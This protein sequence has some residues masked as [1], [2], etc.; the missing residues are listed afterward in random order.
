MRSIYGVGE[1]VLDI[2]FKNGQPVAAKAGGSVL[3]AFVTL[4]RLGIDVQFIS[5]YGT[6]PVGDLIDSFLKENNVSTQYVTR[7]TNGKSTLALA[8]LDEHN[9]ASYSFY[10][11]YPETRLSTLPKELRKDDIL[12]FGSLYAINKE[13]RKPLVTILNRAKTAGSLIFYDPNFRAAHLNELKELKPVIIENLTFADIVRGSDEDF[14]NIFDAGNS[15]EAYEA[16]RQYCPNLV[17]TANREGIFIHTPG[18]RYYLPVNSIEPVSTIGAGDN[19]NAG[20]IYALV[21]QGITTSGL[22]DLV[23]EKW[24]NIAGIGIL[25]ATHVCMSYENYISREFA[26]EISL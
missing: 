19:F 7:Y 12:L 9:N 22:P 1:T 10:K 14:R 16:I 17:Y 5:E 4:G 15:E 3:N 11:D 8:F 18:G 25:L 2:I 13:V 21:K 23:R 20:I 26:Q 24:E 6:E